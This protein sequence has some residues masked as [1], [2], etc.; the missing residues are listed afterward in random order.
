MEEPAERVS[1]N[2]YEGWLLRR[3]GWLAPIVF[4]AVF[5]LLWHVLF[6]GMAKLLFIN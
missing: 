1:T 2:V 3:Y 5:Y 6:G 4:G